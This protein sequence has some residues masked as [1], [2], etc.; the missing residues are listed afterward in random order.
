M[1]AKRPLDAE[2]RKQIRAFFPDRW[3]AALAVFGLGP[4]A[5]D[6]AD[7][8]PDLDPSLAIAERVRLYEQALKADFN[9]CVEEARGSRTPIPT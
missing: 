2:L 4:A 1:S 8:N 5:A 3:Q 7:L 6:A 9:F